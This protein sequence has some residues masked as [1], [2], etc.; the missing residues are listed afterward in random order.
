MVFVNMLIY[1]N[2][3]LRIPLDLHPEVIV[4]KFTQ[5]YEMF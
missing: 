1:C 5:S 3:K 4:I 2:F